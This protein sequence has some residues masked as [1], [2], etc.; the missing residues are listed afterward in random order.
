MQKEVL[1]HA[2]KIGIADV[3]SVH[4]PVRHEKMRDIYVAH[5][6][7]V[8]PTRIEAIGMVI[9]EAMACGLPTITS[10][11]VGANVYVSEGKSGL[12]FETGN[13]SSLAAKILEMCDV[14]KRTKMGINAHE[15]IV[16]HF[17]VERVSKK[18]QDLCS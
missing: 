12:I 6:L 18:F 11:T 4:A 7:L 2:R 3:V 8:L 5:N 14:E 15:R 17:T 9:P 16:Q 13:I 1:E 10:D